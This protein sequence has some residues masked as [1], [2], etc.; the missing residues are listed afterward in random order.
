MNESEQNQQKLE[1]LA[2]AIFNRGRTEIDIEIHKN[3]ND[4]KERSRKDGILSTGMF[5][6]EVINKHTERMQRLLHLQ[7]DAIKEVFFNNQPLINNDDIKFTVEKLEK[8]ATAQ[9]FV[10]LSDCDRF[11]DRANSTKHFQDTMERNVNKI[12]SDIKNDLNIEKDKL[13]LLQQQQTHTVGA[14]S[15]ESK[16]FESLLKSIRNNEL[17]KILL[18]DFEQ[19]IFC[20]KNELWKPCV[21]LCGGILEGVFN[22]EFGMDK[23][24]KSGK[25]VEMRLEDMINEAK[26]IGILPKKHDADLAHA[27][28]AFRNYVHIKREIKDTHSIDDTDAHIAINVVKKVFRMIEKFQQEQKKAKKQP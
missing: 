12:L 18:R 1:R 20:L 16:E 14:K 13:T 23:I 25:N 24:K 19:A 6:R 27:V 26:K 7:L 2:Q 28:R 22:I 9:K 10:I 8:L 4:L 5:I 11:F 17:K 15:D 21:I 3:L